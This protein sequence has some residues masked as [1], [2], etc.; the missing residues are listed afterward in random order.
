MRFQRLF[1]CRRTIFSTKMMKPAFSSSIMQRSSASITCAKPL[2][3][4]E[5]M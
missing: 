2:G 1:S 5:M 4:L 3:R